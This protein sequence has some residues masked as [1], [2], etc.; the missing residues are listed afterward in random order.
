M[1]L[2]SFLGLAQTVAIAALGAL[3][4]PAYET[5]ELVARDGQKYVFAHFIVGIVA[6]YTQDDWTAD[7]KLAQSIG[8]DGFALNIG[9]DGYNDQQLGY[10]YD[11]AAALNFSVFISFDFH[12]WTNDD[13][14]AIAQNLT[15]YSAKPAQF[16]VGEAAFVSSF[17]GDGYDWGSTATQA[18]IQLYACPN[19]QSGSF[20]G[21]SGVSCGFSWNAW[22]S[23]N[24][25]P[26]DQNITTDGDNAYISAL[27]SM[28]YMMPI[29][30]WFN[31]HYGPAPSYDKNWIFYSDWQWNL[32]WQQALQLAPQFLEILTWN[33]FGESHYIGPL[34]PD[35]TDV[36]AGGATGAVQWVTGM[37]HDAWRDVAAPYIKAFKAGAQSPTVDTEELVFYYRPSPKDA[38]C[39]DSVPQPTG[40]DDDDDSVFVIAM[41]TSDGTVVITSGSN[42][43]VSI[44][45]SAGITTVSAPMATGTQTFELLHGTTSAMKGSGDL[46]VSS[47]CTVYNFNA[48]VGSVTASS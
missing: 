28:P 12:Y 41:T 7:M 35:N 44:P 9:K 43:P 4:L 31:T 30:P 23:E 3:A 6:S 10:A 13:V 17:V 21:A 2:S 33:D 26:I 16:K 1:R 22:A 38:P 45:V 37:P 36:Y 34:H 8:I 47:D 20:A 32:R 18:G 24:N 29:S 39:S 25:S 11:A 5:N 14:A 42:A 27:G 19:W 48:F 46:Q 40:Y 15:A